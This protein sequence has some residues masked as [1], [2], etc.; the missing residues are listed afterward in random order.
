MHGEVSCDVTD[1]TYS[2]VLIVPVVSAGVV[3]SGC[4]KV[5]ELLLGTRDSVNLDSGDR[6]SSSSHHNLVL[7][8]NGTSPAENEDYS[9]I[10]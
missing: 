10:N 4:L 9:N 1:N 3:I 2:S 8:F 5:G 7:E 6:T